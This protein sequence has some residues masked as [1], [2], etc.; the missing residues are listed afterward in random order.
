MQKY[1]A[2]LLVGGTL[3]YGCQSKEESQETKSKT[4]VKTQS[5]QTKTTEVKKEIKTAVQDTKDKVVKTANETKQKAKEV[6]KEIKAKATEAKE[7][8]KNAM[9][10]TKQ[11]AKDIKE[12]AEEK[13]KEVKEEAK[14]ASE[15]AKKS[16]TSNIDATALYKPCIACH[17]SK[18]KKKALGKSQIIAEWS[19]DHIAQALT[20]YKNK[21]YGGAMKSMMYGQVS[22]LDE[23]K[24]KALS[25][26]IPTL[27]K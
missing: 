18:G 17:G 7:D 6:K 19:A 4:E 5:Q 16:M 8:V 20:G 10:Q 24:I 2:V 11:K 23:A 26:Y 1:I 13:A 14:K 3:F 27:N 25:E 22:K 12:K 21:T 15:A 9:E